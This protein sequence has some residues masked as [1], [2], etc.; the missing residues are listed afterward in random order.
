MRKVIGTGV[1]ALA[2]A[3]APAAAAELGDTANG[4]VAEVFAE[5]LINE[6]DLSV[7]ARLFTA[8]FAEHTPSRVSAG[9]DQLKGF[10][11]AAFAAFPDVHVDY[12]PLA[13]EGDLITVVGTVTA[14]HTG[15]F[16]GIP[17]SGKTVTWSEL[18]VFRIR[19]DR[20]AEH[21]AE[22]DMFGLVQQISGGGR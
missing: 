21:W 8:D 13:S 14:T 7:A 16:F 17:A 9:I 2:L 10:A 5:Q 19:G 20:I 3:G 22:A 15:D 11:T 18:H 1:I 12:A 6:H 4:R